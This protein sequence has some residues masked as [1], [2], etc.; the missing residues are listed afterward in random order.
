MV[1]LLVV[2]L[3]YFGT[4]VLFGCKLMYDSLH[5]THNRAKGRVTSYVKVP[6][7]Y[8]YICT[9][10]H[11]LVS[12][13]MVLLCKGFRKLHCYDIYHCYVSDDRRNTRC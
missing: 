5:C 10:V 4:H 6:A 8:K 11:V 7:T 3:E 12:T 9:Y 2:I 1:L 13:C